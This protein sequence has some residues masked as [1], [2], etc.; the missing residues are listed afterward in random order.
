MNTAALA[1]ELVNW[2]GRYR[3]VAVAFSGGVDS[4]VVARAAVTA[5]GERAIAVTAVSP[6]LA[7]SDREIAAAVAKQIGI[8][9]LELATHEFQRDEYRRNAVTAAVSSAKIHFTA[10]PS[11][12]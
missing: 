8:R 7:A 2:I 10:S 4:A 3:A 6:S 1:T 11:T 12:E 9:H 5:L